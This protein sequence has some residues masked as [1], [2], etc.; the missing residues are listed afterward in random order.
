MKTIKILKVNSEAI[1]PDYAH[2]G[3]AG[4]DLYSV[5]D[6]IIPS[7]K[8]KIVKTGIAIEMPK[9][10]EAQIRSKS[11]ISAKNGVFVLNSPGTIDEC[12][13]GEL[14][15]ILCNLGEKDYT[16][17]KGEKIA[18]MVFNKVEYLTAIEVDKLSS[19][20]RGKGGFGSTGLKKKA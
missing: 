5:E 19:T 11:G 14:G 18:Q 7:G 1:I 13:R 16:I 3:D 4:M 12:Y 8:Y 15:V 10:L 2:K 20:K 17:K 6:T 9:G